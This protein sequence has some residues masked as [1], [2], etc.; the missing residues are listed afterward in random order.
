[1]GSILSRLFPP[2]SRLEVA[3]VGLENSGKTT[4]ALL[5]CSGE[6]KTKTGTPHPPP[7]IGL[8]ARMVKT[9]NVTIKMWDMSGQEHARRHWS[10]YC[11]DANC[12]VFCVD[13]TDIARIGTARE[14]LAR[15]VAS[16]SELAALP[17]LIC[18]TKCDR[19]PRLGVEDAVLLLALEQL[20][21]GV[22]WAVISCSAV[23]GLRVP[24]VVDWL[25]KRSH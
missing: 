13:S 5:I 16:S 20:P 9:K 12:L 10:R 2:T 18:L 15:L 4:L 19:S 22:S 8:N 7:T 17:L 25:V 14:E 3:F 6:K 11:T 23:T 21:A 24:E 1:M